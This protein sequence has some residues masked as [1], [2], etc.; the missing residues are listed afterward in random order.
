MRL[1]SGGIIANYRCNAACGH[2]LYGSSPK[3]E[4]GYID[5]P[6][7]K[8]LCQLLWQDGCR[9]VHIGGGEPFLNP[10]ALCT[11]VQTVS[12][13]SL[14]LEYIETNAGWVSQDDERN[15]AILRRLHHA[16][17]DCIMFSVDPFHIGYVPL[18]KPI[19]L[20]RLLER[21]GFSYFIWKEQYLRAFMPLNKKR[22]YSPAELRD[23]LGYDACGECARE[24]GLGFNGRA[25]NLLREFGKRQP[26]D[27]VL[28]DKPCAALLA[29]EHFHVDFLGQYVPPRCTGIGIPLADTDCL[30]QPDKKRFPVLHRLRTGGLRTLYEFAQE[31]GFTP[32]P[33]GYVSECELCF[34][35]RK[36]LVSAGDFAELTPKAF[37]AQD[38]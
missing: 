32:N 18:W 33:D 21:E 16:G 24:Y 25:L 28:T 15:L 7:A 26:L 31:H 13:S 8:L 37:Y 23:A 35:M 17:A 11:L 10:D 5:A 9:N 19:A 27:T 2:C 36:T 20:R 14:S 12:D 1:D 3:A 4:P 22:T 29:T 38:F 34:E 6:T 30:L